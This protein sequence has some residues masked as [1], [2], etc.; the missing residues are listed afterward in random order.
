M[1]ERAM[2]FINYM[3]SIEGSLT[4]YNGAKDVSWIDDNGTYKFTDAFL[5]ARKNDEN[6][7]LTTGARKYNTW[8]GLNSTFKLDNGQ[9][10]ELLQDTVIERETYTQVDKDYC[11]YYNI[12]IKGEVVGLTAK[13]FMSEEL[14][15][16][17]T[18]QAPDDVKLQTE[19]IKAYYVKELPKLVLA[20][21]DEELQTKIEALR[22][23]LIDMGIKDE[24]RLTLLVPPKADYP[25]C[26]RKCSRAISK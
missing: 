2:E 6:Y 19:Q 3:Y 4:M 5:E 9:T 15:S 21:S 25:K 16:K 7:V 23:E 26:R 11:D 1:P 12:Q 22:K 20:K 17:F 8:P 14:A 13:R 24:Q 10:V 18:T